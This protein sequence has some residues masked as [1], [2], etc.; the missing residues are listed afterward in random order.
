MSS[1]QARLEAIELELQDEQEYLEG[2]CHVVFELIE[3][4]IIPEHR[5]AEEYDWVVEAR[6]RKADMLEIVDARMYD[7]E[8]QQ[9]DLERR[10]ELLARTEDT[11]RWSPQTGQL[12]TV[13]VPMH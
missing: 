2:D 3:G 7:L 6:E 1:K 11:S 4:G 9:K 13:R 5:Q 12:Y 8:T 10:Y